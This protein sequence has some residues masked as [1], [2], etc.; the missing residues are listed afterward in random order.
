MLEGQTKEPDFPPPHNA[1]LFLR[2][3]TDSAATIFFPYNFSCHTMS[4]PEVKLASEL[5]LHVGPLKDALLSELHGCD[6][7][8]DL[9][10]NPCGN[11]T[12]FQ[13]SLG[14][15]TTSHEITIKPSRGNVNY[16]KLGKISERS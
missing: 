16:H 12:T 8:P 15:N 9:L 13:Q 1:R 14:G 7:E 10:I 5:L 4:R 3:P 6:K 2:S 11:E